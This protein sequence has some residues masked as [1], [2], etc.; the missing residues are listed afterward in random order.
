M[1]EVAVATLNLF[2]RE[3]RWPVRAPLVVRQFLEL[4]PDVAGLQ[5]VDHVIDQANWLVGWIN[6]ELGRPEYTAY[7][8]FNPR[9]VAGP[10][11]LA[12]VSRLPVLEHDGLDYLA[13]EDVAHRV[14][15]DLGGGGRLDL[16]N[17]HLYYR[18]TAAGG[19]VRRGEARRLVEWADAHVGDAPRVLVGDFNAP[20]GG[21]TV[22]IFKEAHRSAYEAVHGREPRQTW[23]T[24]LAFT[25]DAMRCYG[26]A[27]VP[28]AYHAVFDYIFVSRAIEVLDARLAF[29]RS[30]PADDT[31]YPS[32]HFGLVA[33]LRV[34]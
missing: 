11:S 34:G 26:V 6:A 8:M 10:E 32:D 18:Q 20:A 1:A 19:R 5:E 15:L 13:M 23:P 14:R 2:N 21:G 9:G 3:G 17:T 25:V 33:R 27:V 31:L 4:A 16:Y 7:H 24:P 29:D 30:D 28:A 22:A 12:I